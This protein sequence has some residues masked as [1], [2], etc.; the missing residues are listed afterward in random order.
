MRLITIIFLALTFSQNTYSACN[1]KEKL[2]EKEKNKALSII[3]LSGTILKEKTGK[4]EK[5]NPET[6]TYEEVG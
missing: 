1:T 3:G 6:C 4:Y 5:Y 2:E